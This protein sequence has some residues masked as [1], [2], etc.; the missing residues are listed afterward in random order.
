MGTTV[1]YGIGGY[2]PDHPNGN[3]V[4]KVEDNLDGTATVTTWNKNGE[5]IGSEKFEYKTEDAEVTPLER[6][7]SLEPAQGIAVLTLA[8]GLVSRAGEI[9]DGTF[10]MANDAPGKDALIPIAEVVLEAGLALLVD[11]E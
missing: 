4:E 5:V 9:W 10:T 2:Q 8:L 3:I 1:S 7:A 11:S 6:F